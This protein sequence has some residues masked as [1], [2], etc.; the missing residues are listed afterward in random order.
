MKRS[1]IPAAACLLLFGVAAH[2]QSPRLPSLPIT[3]LD[4]WESVE[5]AA[6][7][8]KAPETSPA[9]D[10]SAPRLVQPREDSAPVAV[11]EPPV[12]QPAPQ[13][14]TVLNASGETS[15]PKRLQTSSVG[16]PEPA[17]TP[18]AAS[19]GPTPLPPKTAQSDAPLTL[20][21]VAASP[22]L[23][24]PAQTAMP[25][26]GS[27]VVKVIP[28]VVEVQPIAINH[29]NR[30][31]APFDNPQIRTVSNV[32]IQVN[33]RIIYLVSHDE[34]P[35]SLY[36]TT[37]NESTAISLALTPQKIPPRDMQLVLMRAGDDGTLIPTIP[38]PSAPTKKELTQPYV[39]SQR[40]VITEVAMGKVPTGYSYQVIKSRI[41]KDIHVCAINGLHIQPKQRLD[42]ARNIV[43]VSSVVNISPYP[44][45][46]DESLCYRSGV[47]AV[48]AWPEVALRP[49]EMTE[50]YISQRREVY[51]DAPQENLRPSVIA[52]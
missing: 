20:P 32:D 39:E 1:I 43:T 35:I 36:I 10:R 11:E 27:K 8:T 45:E 40:E 41:P 18:Q 3:L 26:V 16:M 46:I 38:A 6:D 22:R 31:T 9:S 37:P 15:R 2:A 21:L 48:A 23:T 7:T 13:S 12:V 14:T 29:L 24:Q 34:T 30:I 33:G 19:T 4:D 17:P 5:T 49:G 25:D 28:G 51:M 50:L 52:E 42:G 44:I 47:T